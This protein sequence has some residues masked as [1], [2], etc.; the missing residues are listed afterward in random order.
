MYSLQSDAFMSARRCHITSWSRSSTVATNVILLLVSSLT[1][2]GLQS[3]SDVFLTTRSRRLNRQVVV[4]RNNER[5]TD[6]NQVGLA[7]LLVTPM[8]LTLY[9]ERRHTDN[10]QVGLA[11]LLVTPTCLPFIV[12]VTLTTT[13]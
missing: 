6:N 4:A 13:R 9:S 11:F 1:T 3:D 2:S 12:N 7:F 8:C 5:H 10:N